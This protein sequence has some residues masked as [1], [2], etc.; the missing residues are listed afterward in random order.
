MSAAGPSQGAD[1]STSGGSAAGALS[2]PAA[3]V[4]GQHPNARLIESF[5]NAFARRDGRAMAACYAVDATFADPVFDLRGAEIGAMWTM[6]CERAADLRIEARDIAADAHSGR[7]HWE[8]WYTF[9]ASGRPVHNEIDAA[10]TFSDGMIA[11][12]RDIFDLWR[13]SRM[14]L[15]RKGALLGWS[16]LVRKAIRKE[17]RRSLDAWIAR[18]PMNA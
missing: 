3:S 4:E 7:A 12:H 8:A 18:A 5:Y 11:S 13:W 1:Y 17:A 2:N 14:A 6:L 10:F 16:P 15:G 9:S